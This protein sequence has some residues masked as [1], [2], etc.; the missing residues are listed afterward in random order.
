M[1]EQHQD[2]I[3]QVAYHLGHPWK[4][5]HLHAPSNWRY[6][7]IDGQ[8]RVLFFRVDGKQFRISGFLPAGYRGDYT[9]IGVSLTRDPNAI[10]ADIMRRLLPH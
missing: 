8:G 2:I 7:V 10:A 6:E 3:E 5:N 1:S 4:F 9:S